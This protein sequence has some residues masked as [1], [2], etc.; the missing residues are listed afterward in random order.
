M[1]RQNMEE[2]FAHGELTKYLY[3]KHIKKVYK[4]KQKDSNPIEKWEMIQTSNAQKEK[5]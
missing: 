5:N 1:K 4:L 3:P 2:V